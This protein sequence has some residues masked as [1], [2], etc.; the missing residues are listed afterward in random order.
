MVLSYRTGQI[1]IVIPGLR[2]SEEPGTHDRACAYPP[3]WSGRTRSWVPG[4]ALRAAPE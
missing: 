2:V 4:S 1:Q 3:R